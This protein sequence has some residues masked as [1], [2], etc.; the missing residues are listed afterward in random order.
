M[1]WIAIK[2][3]VVA[4]QQPGALPLRS[5]VDLTAC[6]THDI[7]MAVAK[8]K[9]AAVST[10]DIKEAF[11]PVLTEIGEPRP[12]KCGLPQG[13]PICPILFMLYIAPL[14]K[15]EGLKRAFG[16]VD[17]FAVLMIS[18]TSKESVEKIKMAINQ[19]KHR[20][21]NLSPVAHTNSFAISESTQSLYL[22]WLAIY[23]D[24][25]LTFKYH[26]NIQAA[27]ALKVARA[28]KYLGNTI[29]VMSPRLS[30]QAAVAIGTHINTIEEIPL[31]TARSIFPVFWTIPSILLRE[32]EI[33]PAEIGG[34]SHL[35]P[36]LSRFSRACRSISASEYFD[37]LINPPWIMEE[38]KKDSLIRIS[39]P[40]RP[41][42]TS[43][44]K[45]CNFLSTLPGSDIQIYSDGS[46]L[47]DTFPLEKFKDPYDAESHAAL[48]EIHAAIKLPSARFANNA[49][50]FIDSVEVMEVR[51]NRWTSHILTS[52]AQL[53]IKTAAH[54]PKELFLGRKALGQIITARTGHGDF[55]VYHKRFKHERAERNCRGSSTAPTNFLFYQ[56][57][58]RRK[59]R[60]TGPI[61]QL[62]ISLLGTPEEAKILTEWLA[63][64]QFFENTC[65]R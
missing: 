58:C 50:I 9:T 3:K 37:P 12:I 34:A 42:K 38:T 45:F 36:T 29:R 51:N 43:A 39:D 30:I 56:I 47:L 19:A 13:S 28:V 22:R 1:S 15:L 63:Q 21:K 11:D 49:W 52:N 48:Q 23:F 33:L 4:R 16:Y 6:L 14:Y 53:E 61:N 55:V 44:N 8:G 27:K 59:G 25:K 60:P 35:L 7:E 17:D 57:L 5:S 65:P 46:K 31:A 41:I 64:T 20:D 18:P 32:S 24:K 26:V 54:L 2:Y 10:L 62:H 40:L